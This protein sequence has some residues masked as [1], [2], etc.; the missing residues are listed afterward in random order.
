MGVGGVGG[1]LRRHR[2]RAKSPPQADTVLGAENAEILMEATVWQNLS[3][4]MS[5]CGLSSSKEE[6]QGAWGG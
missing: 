2:R 4:S 6:V 5:Q 1:G 3:P